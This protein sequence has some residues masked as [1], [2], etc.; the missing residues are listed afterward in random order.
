[1]ACHRCGVHLPPAATCDGAC[2]SAQATGRPAVAEDGLWE[3]CE[4][5]ARWLGAASDRGG[6]AQSWFQFEVAA[7]GPGG[8][9][10]VHSTGPFRA[11]HRPLPTDD[12]YLPREEW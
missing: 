5:R 11:A 8:P 10:V 2:G 6:H 1:M 12:G 9:Y 3:H 4:I 7:V